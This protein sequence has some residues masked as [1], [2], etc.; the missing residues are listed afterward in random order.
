MESLLSRHA[1]AFATEVL[2]AF[3]AVVLQGARQVGKSTFAQ[4]LARGREART[5]TLDDEGLRAAATADPAAFI[6]QA[7]NSLLVIDELQR[8]PELILAIKASIDRDRRPG[9]FLLTGSSNLLRLPRTPD[10]LAGR[11]ITVELRGLSQG[12]LS[13]RNDDLISRLRNGFAI[14]DFETGTTRDD[15]AM[16]IA[17]GGYPEI[18]DLGGRL[19]RSWL[20]SYLERLLER[21]L[22]DIAPRVNPSRT[23]S[24]FRLLAGNQAGELVKS[25]VARDA[26]ISEA[27]VAN[28]LDLLETMYLTSTIRPWTPNLTSR[29]AAR[30]KVVVNDT[31]LALRVARVTEDQLLPVESPFIGAA[32]EG[33]VATELLKQRTWSA[34]EFE[35][36]HYRDRNGTEVDLVAEFNDGTVIAFEVKSAGTVKTEHFRG[37]TFLRD[38]LGDRFLGGYVLNRTNR[39]VSFGDRLASLPIAALWEA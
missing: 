39:G 35:L 25:R 17:R 29:E 20:D 13:G 26:G 23:A 38:R 22:S 10:S 24:V 21:D 16:R 14:G 31:A 12:E 6:D 9:R 27:S 4:H 33:F 32:I 1:E 36:F 3:P 30:P 2:A 18:R 15:Y 34:E 8:A 11:A 37:L 28:H 5:V 19:R 7:A